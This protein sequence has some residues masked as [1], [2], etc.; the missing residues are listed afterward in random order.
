MLGDLNDD[1]HRLGDVE[2]LAGDAH[3]RINDGNLAFWELNV[4]G[5]TGD[6]NNPANDLGSSSSHICIENPIVSEIGELPLLAPLSGRLGTLV[7]NN[8]VLPN[9]LI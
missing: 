6:L 9:F 2:A 1:V 8:L 7:G 5:G 3:S 4:D